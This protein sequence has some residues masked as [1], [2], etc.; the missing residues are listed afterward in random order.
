MLIREYIEIAEQLLKYQKYDEAIEC[1]T[2]VINYY[3]KS[4]KAY[5]YLGKY[6]FYIGYALNFV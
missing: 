1:F 6:P 3:Q 5:C 4:A 2:F